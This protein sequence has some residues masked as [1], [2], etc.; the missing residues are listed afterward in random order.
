MRIN[1]I[2][3]N[4]PKLQI[5]KAQPKQQSYA[6]NVTFGA[7]DSNIKRNLVRVGA[8]AGAIL[9]LTSGMSGCQA[10]VKPTQPVSIE[11]TMGQNETID[12]LGTI[13]DIQ[14][15]QLPNSGKTQLSD[16][17]FVSMPVSEL[18]LPT[19]GRVVSY[20]PN[21]GLPLNE[22]DSI[23]VTITEDESDNDVEGNTLGEIIGK[24]YSTALSDYSGDEQTSLRNKIIDEVIQAN[25]ALSEYIRAELGEDAD[26]YDAIANLN[27]Y[28]GVTSKDQA[29]DTRLLTMP[30]EIVYMA[31]GVAP[32]G[33]DNCHSMD[34]YVPVI[35]SASVVKDSDTLLDGEFSSFPEMIYSAYGEDLTD[36][37]Y[38]DIVY[39]V[40]NA[41]QNAEV[42]E[43][44]LDDMNFQE[45]VATGN[46]HDLNRVVEANTSDLLLG[47]TLPSVTTLRTQVH[48]IKVD[49]GCPNAPIY[50]I[51]PSAPVAGL[52]DRA[53]VLKDSDGKMQSGDVYELRHVLQY[54]YS[55]N[56]E[57]R[58]GH[59]DENGTFWVQE[60]IQYWDEFDTNIMQQVVY[61]NLDIFTTPYEDQSGYHKYGVFDVNPDYDVTGKTLEEI[62]NL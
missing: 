28:T 49:D 7:E 62:N 50:Q 37:A 35:N 41:P 39:A 32:S 27:L 11:E 36:E 26:S 8:G 46:I 40:V 42:F 56:G 25:P 16:I 54:Y 48:N 38:R 45:L 57:P 53:I 13:L 34:T 9:A 21:E 43:Y 18:Y 15:A 24:V 10:E 51:S 61:A 30:M 55:P 29:L 60:G 19:P 5:K 58:F 2:S 47:I 23:I 33:I 6:S 17:G 59:V 22:G 20:Y 12:S 31:Q 14:G 4:M 3:A 1:N 52:N 44:V